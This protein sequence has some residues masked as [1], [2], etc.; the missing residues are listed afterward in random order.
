M[1]FHRKWQVI[2][3]VRP[4][5]VPKYLRGMA[6]GVTQVYAVQ[7]QQRETGRVGPGRATVVVLEG[8]M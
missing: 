7:A 3:Q 5:F 2:A 8:F 6:A 4:G 1:H